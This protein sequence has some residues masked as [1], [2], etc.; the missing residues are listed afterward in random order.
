MG[1]IMTS[2]DL[3]KKDLINMVMIYMDLMKMD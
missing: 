2:M 3:M 1:F